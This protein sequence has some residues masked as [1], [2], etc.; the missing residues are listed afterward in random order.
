[1]F[2]VI[3]KSAEDETLVEISHP[4]NENYLIQSPNV[5]PMLGDLCL[6]AYDVFS[7]KRMS[8]LVLEL[9]RLKEGILNK[10]D[11]QHIDDIIDLA[12]Q[13]KDHRGSPLIFTRF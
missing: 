2:T 4:V 11:L 10:E 12:N 1:M 13:C 3:W 7:Y 9:K 6:D 8:A 5:Y